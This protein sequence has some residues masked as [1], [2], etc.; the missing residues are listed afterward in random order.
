MKNRKFGSCLLVV[1]IFCIAGCS[2]IKLGYG[3]LDWYLVSKIDDYFDLSNDQKAVVKE[4]VLILIKWHRHV[5][6]PQYVAFL[7][8]ARE[9]LLKDVTPKEID[10]I[11]QQY[12]VAKI[13]LFEH[14]IPVGAKL[15]T[16]LNK[17]QVDYFQKEIKE[18]NEEI[19]E[20][21]NLSAAEL[22]KKRNEKA[23]KSYADW[24]GSL[25]EQQEKMIVEFEQGL[26]DLY[27]EYMD[28]RL[29]RQGIFVNTLLE[30][31]KDQ[32]K[33]EETLKALW[34]GDEDPAYREKSAMNKKAYS[35]FMPIFY[36]S[37]TA[38]QRSY[39]FKKSDKL[40]A[41][42]EELSQQQ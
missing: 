29:K 3:Y 4:E 23:L 26:S 11:F 38:E 8:E 10:Y 28:Q 41:D 7:K 6:L 30:F 20:E 27:A 1:F 42:F 15:L 13:R 25:N 39:F 24:V 19:A 5:E 32:Q 2:S 16:Q 14:C 17:N 35:V 40:I 36:Q 21:H 18:S 31:P 34:L 37:M 22:N 33:L 9:K 12:E